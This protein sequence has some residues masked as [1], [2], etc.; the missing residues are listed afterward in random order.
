MSV[1]PEH[2]IGFEYVEADGKR[3]RKVRL[4]GDEWPRAVEDAAGG[5]L[6]A[7]SR[8]TTIADRWIEGMG[9]EVVVATESPARAAAPS[10]PRVARF[11]ATNVSAE[12]AQI[13][14]G[15]GDAL[16]RELVARSPPKGGHG[17]L[18]GA[19]RDYSGDPPGG[20]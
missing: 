3:W 6:Y 5:A 17:H 19:D 8:G 7:M 1:G 9:Y 2:A 18:Y 13:A 12:F 20:R 4:L 11:V 16:E 14:E 10:E 15:Y